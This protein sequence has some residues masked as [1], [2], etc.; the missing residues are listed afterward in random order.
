MPGGEKNLKKSEIQMRDP[1]V[2]PVEEEGLYYLFGTTDKDCWRGPAVGFNV[3]VSKDLEDWEGPYP[4]F[5]PATDFWSDQNYW[6]PEVF[7]YQGKYYMFAS[8]KAAGVCRGTQILVA[9][10]PKGP[11][12]PHSDGPVTPR[13]WECLDGTLY[14][15]P[16]GNPWMVFC[17]EWVQIVDGEI[18]ALP[19]SKDL[20]EAAGKPHFLF[21]ASEAPWARAFKRN[22]NG[23]EKDGYVTDGPFLYR[24]KS[25]ALLMLWSSKGD[26]GY[27]MGIA[28]SE[29]GNILGPWIQEP[30]PIYGKDGGHGMFFKTFDGRLMMTIHTP[31]QTPNE[32][33][34][35]IEVVEKNNQ[36]TIK[37]QP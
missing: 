4:A 25:N 22:F 35:F 3:Y 37:E 9:D 11:F 29:T 14:V 20:K 5:R 30:E 15:D 27:T 32:R 36:L 31:N 24:T 26:Q 34:I 8:F 19:L 18:H 28:R 6:A 1:F 2:L 21:K 16:E 7:A 12:V 10:H 33:P 23:V 13:D 17:H